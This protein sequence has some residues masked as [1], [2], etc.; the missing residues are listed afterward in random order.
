MRRSLWLWAALLVFP[1]SAVCQ[2]QEQASQGQTQDQTRTQQ[3]QTPAMQQDSIAAAARRAREQKKDAPKPAKVF[4]NDNLPV[5]GGISTVGAT[6][7]EA[8]GNN[9]TPAAPATP[10]SSGSSNDEKSWR[11]RF[12]KLRH[13]LEQDQAELD[14]MQRE[15]G[16]LD[17]Q[18]Y[19]DPVKAMQQQ[20]TRSDINKKN[21]S[22]EDMKKKVEADK[23]AISDA[24]DDLRRSGGDSGWAR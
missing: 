9:A 15:A 16:V 21:A 19:N 5:Q 1:A 17:L 20:L 11:D 23:Q 12:A 24:E 8:A 18:Y 2:Q 6:P 22:I 14:V 4:D 3:T 7:A 10:S 13:K